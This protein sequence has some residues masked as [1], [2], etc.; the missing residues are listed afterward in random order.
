[1]KITFLNGPNLNLLGTREPDVYGSQTLAGI[2]REVR[3]R[4]SGLGVEIDFR[5]TN[6]EAELVTWVQE[7]ATTAGAIVLNAA[8]FTHTSI[9][10]RDAI[11][12]SGAKVVEI[13]LSNT[14][15]RESFRHHSHLSAVCSGV[16]AGFG[17]QSY[18]LGLEAAVSVAGSRK[19]GISR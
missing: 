17:A 19:G 3:E 15:A 10:L 7:A 16:I 13:H 18:L 11:K 4:A 12:G 9:A 1:M 2:E 6:S 5:Q 14:H 8:A